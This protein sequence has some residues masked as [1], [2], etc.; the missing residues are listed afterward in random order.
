MCV[1]VCVCVCVFVFVFVF[2]CVCVCE[3]KLHAYLDSSFYRLHGHI[4]LDR[5]PASELDYCLIYR[6]FLVGLIQISESL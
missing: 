4:L 5:G 1:C 6:Y 3:I 2:V